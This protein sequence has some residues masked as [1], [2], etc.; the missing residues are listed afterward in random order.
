M[1]LSAMLG[2]DLDHRDLGLRGLVADLVHHVRGL[3]AEQARHLDVDAGFGDALLPDRM[4]EIDLPKATRERGACTSSPALLRPPMVR[5]QWWMRPGPRRPCAISKPRPSPSSM[6]VAGHADVL[7]LD[8]HVAVRRIVIAEHRQHGGQSSRPA[9]PA[10]RGSATAAVLLCVGSVL[11][12]TIAI[13]QRGSP[14]PDDH[15]LVPLMTYSSPSRSMR[16]F[17]V[18]GVGRGDGRLGHQEGRTDFAVHQRLQP[19][20]LLLGVP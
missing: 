13:L 2:P 19:L 6:L 10:A 12:I 3:Q 14:A 9:R 17:D 7:Q 20:F 11:P 16:T 15:H 4:L 8:F 5:M 18:G 1:I